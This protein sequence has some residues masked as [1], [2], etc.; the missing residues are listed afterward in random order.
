MR[1]SYLPQVCSDGLQNLGVWAPV[2]ILVP[3]IVTKRKQKYSC[4]LEK[5]ISQQI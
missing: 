4:F 2:P 5:N 3:Y 1:L